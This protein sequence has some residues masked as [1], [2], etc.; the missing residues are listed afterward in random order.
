[1]DPITSIAFRSF[2]DNFNIFNNPKCRIVP[3]SPPTSPNKLNYIIYIYP[4]LGILVIQSNCHRG[5]G[6]MVNELEIN[7]KTLLEPNITYLVIFISCDWFSTSRAAKYDWM[8]QTKFLRLWDWIVLR[9]KTWKLKPRKKFS[10]SCGLRI[11]FLSIILAPSSTG[12]TSSRGL[13]INAD[14]VKQD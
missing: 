4:I 12:K 8:W 2:F 1:M 6:K 10:T 14:L 3:I 13:C 9:S 5:Y 7:A 11:C